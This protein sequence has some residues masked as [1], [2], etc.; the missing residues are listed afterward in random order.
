VTERATSNDTTTRPRIVVTVQ[1]PVRAED[2]AVAEHKNGRYVDGVRRHGGDPVVLDELTSEADRA[3]AFS[4]MDGLLLSGGADVAPAYYGEE[5]HRT[6][7]VE[8]ERDRLEESAF[9]AAEA[10]GVPVFGI[11]RGMQAINVF[12]GGA[13]VQDIGG[14][15]SPAYP[16]PQY[17]AHELSVDPESRLGGLLSETIASV[18]TYHHQAVRPRDLGHGLRAVGTSP[19][20]DGDLVEAIEDADPDRWLFGVQ[21]HPERTE[22][23]PAAF[24]NLWR[25]FIGAARRFADKREMAGAS[26]SGGAAEA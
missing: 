23:T 22:S 4:E 11:C 26:R 24:E 25:D 15:T 20:D 6:T 14:H 7:V 13:L 17:H 3:A 5:P 9:R 2:A 19:H 10:R 18:N 8:P 1:A 21:S 16:A 12:R